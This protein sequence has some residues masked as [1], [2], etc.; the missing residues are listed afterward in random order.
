MKK[1]LTVVSTI[2]AIVFLVLAI[3][4]WVT[5]AGSLPHMFPGYQAG[6]T[7]VHLKHG[8]ASLILAIAFAVLAWFSL[9]K[10]KKAE[11]SST[12]ENEDK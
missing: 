2:L 12:T 10:K 5:P 6:S 9:G 4:Y 3:Y 8:L 1:P 7:H 11:S